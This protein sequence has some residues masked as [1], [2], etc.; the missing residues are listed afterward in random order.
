M[1]L[2]VDK[3]HISKMLSVTCVQSTKQ[4][5]LLIYES[6]MAET[7][8]TQVF[9]QC[10]DGEGCRPGDFKLVSKEDVVSIWLL[11]TL[12]GSSRQ[13]PGGVRRPQ[14]HSTALSLLNKHI[15]T[16]CYCCRRQATSR[17]SR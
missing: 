6:N 10:R 7:D 3:K 13:V 11:S 15:Y 17:S 12:R 5:T 16:I 4:A 1:P 14:Q 8:E 9:I 2:L